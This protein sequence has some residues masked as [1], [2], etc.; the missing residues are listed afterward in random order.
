MNIEELRKLYPK[1]TEDELRI[2]SENLDAYL[3]LAWEIFEENQAAVRAGLTG[4]GL[5]STMQG[6]VDS[7]K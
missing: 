7:T 2:A 5:S 3:E 6:K 4:D 1:L